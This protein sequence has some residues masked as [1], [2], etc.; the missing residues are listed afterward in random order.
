MYFTK[1]KKQFAKNLTKCVATLLHIAVLKIQNKIY[2][3][4]YLDYFLLSYLNI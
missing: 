3:L 1:K 4:I 2:C